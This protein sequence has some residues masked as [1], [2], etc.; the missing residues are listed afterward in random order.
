MKNELYVL[1]EKRSFL[2]LLAKVRWNIAF[3]PIF[4]GEIMKFLWGRFS[5]SEKTREIVTFIWQRFIY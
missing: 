5:Q 1:K 3:Y 4:P 2:F